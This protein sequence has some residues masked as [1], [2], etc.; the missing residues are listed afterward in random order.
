[1][2]S[3]D[4]AEYLFRRLY[5]L[6]IRAIHG[7]PGDYNLA[8]LDY[9]EP[10]G[11]RWIG[12]CNELNAG[13]AADGYARI[14][15][16]GVVVTAFG[17]GELS[18]INAIAGA[19]AEKAPVV[20]IVG[21]PPTSA[22]RSGKCL[23]H[24]LGIG[25]FDIFAQMYARVTA[26]QANL[27]DPQVAAESIDAVLRTCKL[28]SRPVYIRLP[29]DMVKAKIDGARLHTPIDLFPPP[30]DEGFEDAEVETIL[31]K[32]Y[33]AKSPAIVVDGFVRAYDIREEV[34]RLVKILEVPTFTTPFG[35][36]LVSENIPSFHG[37]YDGLSAISE[38]KEYIKTFDLVLRFGPLFS[39]VNTCG[40]TSIFPNASSI[41]FHQDSVHFGCSPSPS[42][43]PLSPSSGEVSDT[44]TDA[45]SETYHNLHV[46]SLLHKLLGKLDRNLIPKTNSFPSAYPPSSSTIS[47]LAPN[48]PLFHK[49]FWPRLSS[50]LRPHDVIMTET[51][52]ASLGGRELALPPN[53]TMI[54]SSLW[55]S[56]GYMFAAAQGVAL[57]KEEDMK[58]ASAPE[59]EKLQHQQL[60]PANPVSPLIDLNS[61]KGGRTILLTGDGSFQVSCQELSTIIRHKVP[62]LVIFLINNDGYTIERFIHGMKASYNDVGR[63]KYLKAGEFFGADEAKDSGYRI[64]TKEVRCWGEMEDVMEQ[65]TK[66]GVKGDGQDEG[67]N[68]LWLIEVHMEREDAPESLKRLVGKVTKETI[69]EV[70]K[71]IAIVEVEKKEGA[72]FEAEA[73][74]EPPTVSQIQNLTIKNAAEAEIATNV[75]S[76]SKTNA[77]PLQTELDDNPLTIEASPSVS[78]SVSATTDLLVQSRVAS[79]VG[80]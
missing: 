47:P 23:H 40:F 37:I 19:E 26:A 27:T 18:A 71:E 56:I 65:L 25:D 31:N 10:A 21:T 43:S 15:G 17:V 73:K 74:K 42:T 80:G 24:S 75:E 46:K 58:M 7:V 53:T 63:W 4:L 6:G 33:R 29:L 64:R 55:L 11:L 36:S 20:H 34:D 62:N 59:P 16:L 3:I 8:A 9:V 41:D 69:E 14:K 1:M 52:T 48:T 44:D 39:D 54:N 70:K 60:R 5:Q 78:V 49:D 51:G 12:N 72:K 79:A 28:Q 22:Q 13:Y 35:K 30:N 77:L 61:S 67:G 57:A 50:L 32:I 68:G 2:E 76:D 45:A 66:F 38:L